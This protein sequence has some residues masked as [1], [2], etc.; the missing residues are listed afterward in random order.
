M[1]TSMLW[2]SDGTLE[3]NPISTKQNSNGGMETS[4]NIKKQT[5]GHKSFHSNNIYE[6]SIP[7]KVQ[8]YQK[9]I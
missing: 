8:E 2:R 3:N 5:C 7:N 4:K 9:A 1:E 6:L